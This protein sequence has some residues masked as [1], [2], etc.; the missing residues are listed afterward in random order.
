MEQA[1][2]GIDEL[3]TYGKFIQVPTI[4]ANRSDRTTLK[5]RSL[6][7][8]LNTL[9]N[10]SHGLITFETSRSFGKTPLRHR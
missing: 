2:G 3:E 10:A 1:L 5:E 6:S 7:I 8:S 4:R 9:R